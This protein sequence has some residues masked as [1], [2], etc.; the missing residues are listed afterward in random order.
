[1]ANFISVK[2]SGKWMIRQSGLGKAKSSEY[3]TIPKTETSCK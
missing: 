1:M 2:F 3:E